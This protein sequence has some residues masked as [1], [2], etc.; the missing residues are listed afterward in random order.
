[1]PVDTRNAKDRLLASDLLR[2]VLNVLL[3][4]PAY[5]DPAK[6]DEGLLLRG[7]EIVEPQ[8]ANAKRQPK[9]SHKD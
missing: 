7:D 5:Q 6:I 3:T 9:R 1:V 2:F 4:H 8:K